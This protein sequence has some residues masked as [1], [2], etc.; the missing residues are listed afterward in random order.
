[1][2][3]EEMKSMGVTPKTFTVPANTLVIANV[4]G[5]HRRGHT[6]K[7]VLRDAVHGSIRVNNP[8]KLINDE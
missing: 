8:F 3:E 7:E 2:S 1:V 4:F 5:F 6:D